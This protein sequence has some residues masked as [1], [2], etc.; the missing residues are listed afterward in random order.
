LRSS[1]DD[2]TE[3]LKKKVREAQLNQIPL[4]ITA[5]E[6]ERENKTLSVRTLDGKVRFGI[7]IDDFIKSAL[8]NIQKRNLE[9]DMFND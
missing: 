1:V 9:L 2:R 4:I 3:S 6:K 7:S 8:Y 5:G